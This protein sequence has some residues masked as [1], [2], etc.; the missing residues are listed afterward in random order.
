[1]DKIK[2]LET[3]QVKP[4]KKDKGKAVKTANLLAR[5][6]EE[7]PLINRMEGINSY[8][9]RIFTTPESNKTNKVVQM[10]IDDEVISLGGDDV[11]EDARQFYADND[12][13][14]GDYT[15]YGNGLLN[16]QLANNC[17]TVKTMGKK[18][19]IPSLSQHYSSNVVNTAACNKTVLTVNCVMKASE[20]NETKTS[21]QINKFNETW[22]IDSGASHHITS[23]LTDFTNYTPYPE[24]EIIQTANV[25]DSLMIHGEGTVFLDTETT[26]GQI[27]TV[28]LDNV[29]YIPN[30]SN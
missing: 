11:Y 14:D 19:K 20:K 30:R 29:C 21:L 22:I 4:D 12:V 16:K 17:H 6:D 10:D 3:D 23:K 25:H 8:N 27:H 7:I 18:V 5:I 9:K 26:N 2:T 15:K 24:P 13:L 1:M 28:C